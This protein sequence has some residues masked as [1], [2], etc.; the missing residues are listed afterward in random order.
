MR[1][2]LPRD[3]LARVGACGAG[4]GD[5]V[6][7]ELLRKAR[8]GSPSWYDR[9]APR[10]GISRS[11]PAR[12]LRTCRC[13]QG[14]RNG[15]ERSSGA[16]EFRGRPL[17]LLGRF[18]LT[19]PRADRGGRGARSLA[20]AVNEGPQEVRSIAS[21]TGEAGYQRKRPRAWFPGLLVYFV[22]RPSRESRRIDPRAE[23]FESDSC[24]SAHGSSG[25][26]TSAST[27]GAHGLRLLELVST[28][29]AR[30]SVQRRACDS[31]YQ[32]ESG[33]RGMAGTHVAKSVRRGGGYLPL[34]AE[35]A[36]LAM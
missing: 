6:R 16:P 3:A 22:C 14:G 5:P 11:P 23:S 1:S 4:S 35:F 19:P 13:Y 12:A 28:L 10:A 36:S 29:R 17:G 15:W 32:F 34:L 30:N 2:E 8:W 24:G 7:S 21:W 31:A 33:S 25:G 18:C 20:D 27:R 9:R 26:R